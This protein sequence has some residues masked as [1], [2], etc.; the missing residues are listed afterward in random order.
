M[1]FPGDPLLALDPI[2]L[3]VPSEA[4]DRLLATLD[5]RAGTEGAA[6]GYRFDIVVGGGRA[7][8]LER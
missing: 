7:T 8:P 2:F 5:L 3:S 4:R 1:Y 6:L